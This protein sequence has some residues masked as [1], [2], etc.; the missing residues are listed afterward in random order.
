MAN[1]KLPLK[2]RRFNKLPRPRDHNNLGLVR[3]GGVRAVVAESVL[4]KYQLLILNR[5]RQRSPN[6][7]A[8]DRLIAVIRLGFWIKPNRLCRVAIFKPSTLLNFHRA[9]RNEVSAAV[10]TEAESETR[11]ERPAKHLIRAVVEMKRP[12]PNWGC[13]QI[14]DQINPAFGTSINLY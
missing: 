9:R 1:S 11:A 8:L 3:P 12:N 13:P 6:L 4:A 10:F 2:F 5:S 14:A 7:R